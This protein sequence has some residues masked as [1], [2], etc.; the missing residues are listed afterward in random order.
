MTD[1]QN[2]PEAPISKEPDTTQVNQVPEF[3]SVPQTTPEATAYT[4]PVAPAE[5]IPAPTTPNKAVYKVG[6]PLGRKATA[7]LVGAGIVLN[8]AVGVGVANA[9]GLFSENSNNDKDDRSSSQ[10]Y[11]NDQD[12]NEDI[13]NDSGNQ[14][15][16]T[17]NVIEGAFAHKSEMPD[18]LKPLL[19]S[20]PATMEQANLDALAQYYLDYRLEYETRF[21][22]LSG[23][24]DDIPVTVTPESTAP[25]ILRYISKTFSL[26]GNQTVGPQFLE[27]KKSTTCGPFDAFAASVVINSAFDNRIGSA[28]QINAL[29]EQAGTGDQATSV[30]AAAIRGDFAMSDYIDLTSSKKM[31]VRADG[32]E[33]LTTVVQF[34]TAEGGSTLYE[35]ALFVDPIGEDSDGVMQFTAKLGVKTIAQ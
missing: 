28:T 5:S 19:N 23:L 20:D 32:T 35:Q 4:P 1:L 3:A 16:D 17:N 30:Y 21:V 2:R 13:D 25:E 34:R 8:A 10:E 11:D 26:A 9:T 33:Q 6:W 14:E 31:V 15:T 24:D 27:E 18:S 7:A 12:S 22:E 29:I